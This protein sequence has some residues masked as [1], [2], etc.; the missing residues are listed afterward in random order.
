VIYW[1]IEVIDGTYEMKIYRRFFWRLFL[2]KTVK[3]KA[4]PL[5]PLIHPIDKLIDTLKLY[6]K[7]K[8]LP[9]NRDNPQE[10][11]KNHK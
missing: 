1:S 5:K 10:S 2:I 7:T 3:S 4:N 8:Q 11:P 9:A 6:G